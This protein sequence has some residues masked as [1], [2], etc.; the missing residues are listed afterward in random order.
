MQPI[1]KHVWIPIRSVRVSD[2]DAWIEIEPADTLTID[3]TLA[4]DN[5]VIGTQRVSYNHSPRRYELEIAHARTFG[6]ERDVE[7]L[8]QKGFA[9]GGELNNAVVV[10]EDRVL[11]RDGLRYPDE[12]ARHKILDL[13]G[14]MAMIGGHIV[15][16]IRAYKSRHTLNRTFVTRLLDQGIAEL[17]PASTVR[18]YIMQNQ[19][20]QI[21]IL[22][23]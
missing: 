6:L 8:R 15:G 1:E 16:T 19:P 20:Q 5:A 10:G 23:A 14:D 3:Y 2:G 11:N 22:S 17:T 18:R 12:F 21:E 4:Y 7:M 9:L 13:I